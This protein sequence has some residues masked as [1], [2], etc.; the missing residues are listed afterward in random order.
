MATMDVD[1]T[2]VGKR[3]LK[4]PLPSGYCLGIRRRQALQTARLGHRVH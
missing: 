2:D 3:W 1:L 4:G